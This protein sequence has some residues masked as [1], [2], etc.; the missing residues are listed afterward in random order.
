[1]EQKF[2]HPTT[3]PELPS[4]QHHVLRDVLEE[5]DR[6]RDCWN[7]LKGRLE[8][9]LPKEPKEPPAA[10]KARLG[11]VSYVPFF[12][13]A[14][15]SFAGVLSRYQLKNP[16]ASLERAI[17]DIDRRGND[18]TSFLQ[19]ADQLALRDGG[20]LITVDMPAG[21]VPTN[22]HQ[23]A[24]DR[25]PYL[26]L[27]ERRNLLNWRVHHEGGREVL[28]W[29]VIREWA[30][31]QDGLY[32]VKLK[33]RYRLIGTLNGQA[34]WRLLEIVEGSA[35]SGGRPSV[36]VAVNADGVPQQGYYE[37][38]A[39]RPYPAPPVVWYA[40]GAREGFGQGSIRLSGLAEL[41]LEHLRCRSDH[42][43]LKHKTAMPV[44]VRKGAL[45]G[46]GG[47][48]AP[49]VLGP[50]SVVDLD[51]NGSFGFA[52]PGASSLN[53]LAQDISHI[54]ALIREQTLAF[55]YGDGGSKTATQASLEAAHTEASMRSVATAKNSAV[56]ALMLLWCN[57]TGERLSPEAGITMAAHLFDRPLAAPDVAQLSSLEQNEQ[58]S[59]QSFLEQIIK[60]GVL[61]VVTSAD[62]ELER[63]R[64][65]L[66]VAGNVPGVNDLAGALPPG[67]LPPG[68]L[69][70]EALPAGG[71]GGLNAAAELG[72][73]QQRAV[74]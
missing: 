61:T 64:K 34:F 47:Q 16:P 31:E 23:L 28:D 71:G 4:Y 52:E 54:E 9:Y 6:N 13:D 40:A 37:A 10:Y 50:N 39:G 67:A 27:V 32:G 48:V 51:P 56:Q 12:R 43:E 7:Y 55:L 21:S 2:A 36:R 68:G 42:A 57:F 72:A 5:L 63:L 59:T 60:G 35:G 74:A 58:I 41:T 1:L 73:Q 11:R 46:P 29:L 3:D 38:P 24:E 44:P 65:Q 53:H 14:I 49:L 17:D 33:P 30:E 25:R 22:G 8:H 62:D 18:L 26:A 66:P 45:P 69:P 70:P 15:T 19:Q 20:C